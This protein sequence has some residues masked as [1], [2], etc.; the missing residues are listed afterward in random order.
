ML[1]TTTKN[2]V[3]MPAFL[4]GRLTRAVSAAGFVAAMFLATM[5]A[6]EHIARAAMSGEGAPTPVAES[7][8]AETKSAARTS[9]VEATREDYRQREESSKDLGEFAGG[10]AG[11]YIGGSTAAVVLLI[12]LLII[13][14]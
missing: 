1:T 14:L 5:S 12:V 11:I 10:S 8:K 13:L 2:L 7:S 9:A 4:R 6:T 3:R